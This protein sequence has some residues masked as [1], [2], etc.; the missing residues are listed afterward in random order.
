MMKVVYTYSSYSS[1]TCISIVGHL[2]NLLLHH[3]ILPR[4]TREVLMQR[5]KAVE[6]PA[7]VPQ[8]SK[9]MPQNIPGMPQILQ[10]ICHI[11]IGICRCF[12]MLQ[13]K[14]GMRRKEFN[15]IQPCPARCRRNSPQFRDLLAIILEAGNYINGDPGAKQ[16]HFSAVG[17]TGYEQTM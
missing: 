9:K 4:S 11:L 14:P 13:M 6:N 15:W 5:C 10:L 1:Y 8:M 17:T 3:L 16:D 12:A 7:I 2:S